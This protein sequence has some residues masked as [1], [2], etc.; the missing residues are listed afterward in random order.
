[1]HN[2][3]AT[4]EYLEACNL[5]FEQGILSHSTINV[6]KDG[7]LQNMEKGYKYFKEWYQELR[8]SGTQI[9]IIKLI[10]SIILSNIHVY[11]TQL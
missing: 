10:G 3:N 5:L 6:V 9:S 8:E 2:R 7:V 4:A 1:M 11:R